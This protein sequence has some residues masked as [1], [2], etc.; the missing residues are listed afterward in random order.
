[1][2][3]E[4]LRLLGLTNG[5]SRIYSALLKRGSSTVGPISKESRVSYSKI[6]EVLERLMEKGLV[7]STLKEKTKYFQA[8]EP[9]RIVDFLTKQEEEI[10]EKKK[11][12]SNILPSL[13]KISSKEEK[14]ESEI[15]MGEK[16]IMTAYDLLLEN[17][18]KG[19]TLRYFYVY[20][21]DYSSNVW[22]FYA[23]RLNYKEKKMNPILKSKKINRL[24]LINIEKMGKKHEGTSYRVYTK[25]PLPGNIDITDNSILI[26][27]WGGKTPLGILIQSKEVAK[28]FQEYF[29]AVWKIAKK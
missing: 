21:P 29:D 26:T 24:G 7:S 12:L 6:Y 22:E 27:I 18:K 3:E 8:L 13:N 9:K 23:G 17:A 25:I 5:E 1:M 19:S 11:I 15:F 4:K 10:K 14:Q 28:N 20:N 16:G 2:Y